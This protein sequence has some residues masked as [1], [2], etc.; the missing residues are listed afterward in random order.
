MW[1]TSVLI[2]TVLRIHYRSIMEVLSDPQNGSPMDKLR[3]FLI[4]FLCTPTVSDAEYDQYAGALQVW[5]WFP[6]LFLISCCWQAGGCDLAA[7][8]YLRRWR[9]FTMIGSKNM[10]LN[11]RANQGGTIKAAMFRLDKCQNTFNYIAFYLFSAFWSPSPLSMWGLGW[12][13]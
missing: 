12:R 1:W 4:Y 10:E 3:L 7:L 9:S 11:Q 6:S 8:T 2:F 5:F 13:T